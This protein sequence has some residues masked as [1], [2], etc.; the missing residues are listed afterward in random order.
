LRAFARLVGAPAFW[1]VYAAFAHAV[2]TGQPAATQALPEGLFAYFAAHPEEAATFDAA[3]AAKAQGHVA[4]I[5]AAYDFSSFQQIG[6]IG[7]GRGH[8]LRAVLDA[9]PAATGVLFDLPHVIAEAAA[10]GVASNRLT[11]QAGDFF[12]EALP[13]CD[14]YLL[15]EVLHD[16]GD[17]EAVA[18]L[19]AVR[20]AT[21]TAATL[22]V[23]EQMLPA[24]PGPAWVKTLDIHMLAL[25]GGRQ[26]TR[27]E[28][29]ALLAASG[30]ALE[31][32]IATPAG[33]SILEARAV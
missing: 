12:H 16:W 6:D 30:F 32:E 7:G 26:R 2:R 27:D 25:L 14:A 21:P 11:L 10:A 17:D 24:D 18:L 29:I 9:A 23:L 5:L 3:M 22:L 8:L 28:Y 1:Q 31:R 4:G 20:Q 13:V 19:R 33:I 15:M